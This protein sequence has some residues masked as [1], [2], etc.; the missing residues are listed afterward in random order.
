MRKTPWDKYTGGFDY[1]AI[2]RDLLPRLPS[3]AQV[4]Q[5]VR[6]FVETGRY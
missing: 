1:R 2:L 6:D 3:T 5:K 4:N